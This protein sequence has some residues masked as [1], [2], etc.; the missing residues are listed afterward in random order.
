MVRLGI[1]KIWLE[2]SILNLLGT[3]YSTISIQVEGLASLAF[4]N[5]N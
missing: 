2:S 3:N 1:F 4:V 5:L